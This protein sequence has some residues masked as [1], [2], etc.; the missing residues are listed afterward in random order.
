MFFDWPTLQTM[1]EFDEICCPSCGS[2]ADIDSLKEEK[3]GQV[4]CPLCR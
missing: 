2:L 1:N 3:D 4:T